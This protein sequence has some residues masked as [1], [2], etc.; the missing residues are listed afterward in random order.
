M[1]EM[2]GGGAT[3]KALSPIL[4][5]IIVGATSWWSSEESRLRV[6]VKDLTRTMLK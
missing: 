3:E 2:G 6:L 1:T 5:R 4:E